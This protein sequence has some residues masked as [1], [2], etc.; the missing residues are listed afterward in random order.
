LHLAGFNPAVIGNWLGRPHFQGNELEK[1][2]VKTL[3]DN[4]RFPTMS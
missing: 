3:Y 1:S 4:R 2:R